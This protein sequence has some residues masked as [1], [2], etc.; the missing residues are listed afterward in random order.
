MNDETLK[1][2]INGAQNHLDRVKEGR[3]L[4]KSGRSLSEMLTESIGLSIE[5][6]AQRRQEYL[7]DLKKMDTQFLTSV[8]N[9][10]MY[11]LHRRYKDEDGGSSE[12]EW[13]VNAFKDEFQSR[14][15]KVPEFKIEDFEK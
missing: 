7:D 10:T 3:A 4:L 11:Q 12:L 2:I 14:N 6:M 9:N 15:L 5:E 8:Y 13:R 1:K